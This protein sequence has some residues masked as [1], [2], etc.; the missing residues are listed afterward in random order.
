MD[1]INMYVRYTCTYMCFWVLAF[2][3]DG[4]R[5][6]I[7]MNTITCFR[8]RLREREVYRQIRWSEA[9]IWNKK[10]VYLYHLC[11]IN[12]ICVILFQLDLGISKLWTLEIRRWVWFSCM[13]YPV[14]Y[15]LMFNTVSEKLRQGGLQSAYV[16]CKIQFLG[17]DLKETSVWG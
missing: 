1:V 6:C 8:D 16:Q 4:V 7:N 2:L 17:M 10:H 13:G 9:C 15:E 14:V 5:M 11:D 12:V 3:R